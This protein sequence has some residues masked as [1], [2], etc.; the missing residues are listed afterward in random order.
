M[1]TDIVKL[2]KDP[3]TGLQMYSY[4]YKGDSKE[5]PKVVGPMAQDVE[6]VFPGSTREV[7]G[8]RTVDA[9]LLSHLMGKAR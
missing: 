6:K 5:Y 9:G 7:G 2:D 1:K 8:K 3:D 4:R